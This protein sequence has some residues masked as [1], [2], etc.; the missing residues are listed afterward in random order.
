MNQQ[1]KFVMISLCSYMNMTELKAAVKSCSSAYRDILFDCI[2]DEINIGVVD[3][4]KQW[5]TYKKVISVLPL[6]TTRYIQDPMVIVK[7]IRQGHST[8]TV[9]RTINLTKSMSAEFYIEN[10]KTL[11]AYD[12][13]LKKRFK[14]LDSTDEIHLMNELCED[15]EVQLES[16]SNIPASMILKISSE[17]F[18]KYIDKFSIR[19]LLA[20][21]SAAAFLANNPDYFAVAFSRPYIPDYHHNNRTVFEL[22]CKYVKQEATKKS[23]ISQL[24]SNFGVNDIMNQSVMPVR[25]WN[26][27]A[28]QYKYM[29]PSS[30]EGIKMLNT[31]V[32]YVI[33]PYFPEETSARINAAMQRGVVPYVE[34]AAIMSPEYINFEYTNYVLKSTP[35]VTLMQ[36][37]DKLAKVQEEDI[38]NENKEKAL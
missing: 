28:G 32:K 33:I 25:F 37:L 34:K 16:R 9:K 11:S 22:I 36:L 27:D 38:D 2:I 1:E 7:S 13:E 4:E 5:F 31:L 30:D 10:Y 3:P 24:V 12:A 18:T 19:E 20:N 35:A 17:Q 14:N 6:N 21:N 23:L 8:E 15:V 29:L 26:T